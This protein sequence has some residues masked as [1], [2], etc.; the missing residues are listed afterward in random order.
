MTIAISIKVHDGIV[1]AADSASTIATLTPEGGTA[2]INIYNTARKIFN[3]YR[4]LPI[5][6]LTWGAGSLGQASISTLTK[7][8]RL[9]LMGKDPSQEDY[10]LDPEKYSVKQVASLVRRFFFEEK[11]TEQLG[12]SPPDL[13]LGFIVAGYSPG[14][15]L[16]EEW[17]ILINKG[18]CPEPKPVRPKD[19]T[20]VTWA[21]EQEVMNRLIFG[22]GTE[23]DKVLSEI[24]VPQDQIPKIINFIKLK[25]TKAWHYAAMPIKDAIDLAKFFAEATIMYS[26]FAPGAPTVGGPV[27]VA[28][29][30]KH[31]GFKWIQ[32]KLWYPA[33]LNPKR[34]G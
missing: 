30:T 4:G 12:Q 32:R 31:E 2:V 17:K 28:A 13:S 21:G 3:L 23:L 8:L 26:R 16:A 20:G 24:K 10:K 1:L 9:R 27:D 29:I 34:E 6:L 11:Y 25:L 22:Y 33:E 14:E 19:D 18:N 5:G 7:D 15:D